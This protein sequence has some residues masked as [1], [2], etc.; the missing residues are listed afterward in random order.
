MSEIQGAGV[1]PGT[2]NFEAVSRGRVAKQEKQLVAQR[3]Q[4]HSSHSVLDKAWQALVRKG[5]SPGT[6]QFEI[7]LEV[8]TVRR[9]DLREARM[10]KEALESKIK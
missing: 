9:K 1:E 8:Q 6:P 10:E 5:H 2:D 7:L 3:A 4:Y